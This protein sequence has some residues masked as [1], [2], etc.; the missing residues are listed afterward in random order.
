M[1]IGWW[2]NELEREEAAAR[3]LSRYRAEKAREQRRVTSRG[4]TTPGRGLR[5]ISKEEAIAKIAKTHPRS[6][7]KLLHEHFGGRARRG[8]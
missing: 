7:L 6:A 3:A 2:V 4:T 5:R 1:N 8:N